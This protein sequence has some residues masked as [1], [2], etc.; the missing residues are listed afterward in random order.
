MPA[1]ELANTRERLTHFRT[2]MQ[3]LFEAQDFLLAPCAPI[4]QLRAGADHTESRRA[5]LRYTTPASLAGLPAITIPG[6]PHGTGTQLLAAPNNDAVLAAF[7]SQ[8]T[9]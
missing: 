8:L 9:T 3:S 5:I 2:Q 1:A 4:H 7:A 6:K